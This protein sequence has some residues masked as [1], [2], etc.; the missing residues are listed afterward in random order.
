MTR[1]EAFTEVIKRHGYR[2]INHFCL[3]NKISQTNMSKRMN[4][5]QK[6][7]LPLLFRWANILH[8]PI[9]TMLEV[10]YSEEMEE[11]RSNIE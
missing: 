8:E 1:S 3:E 6:I 5:K 11:N 4:G 2:S 10:F 9:D 7:E